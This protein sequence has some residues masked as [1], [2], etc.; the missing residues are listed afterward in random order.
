[1]VEGCLVLDLFCGDGFFSHYFYATIAGHID[2]IDKSPQ[3]I[4]HAQKWHSHPKI[5]Y[6]VQDVVL[7]DF[8]RPHYD[9][10]VWFEAIEHLSQVDYEKAV[11]RIKSAL[12]D[13]GVLIGSTP[14]VPP[15]KLG[16]AN[17]EHQNEFSEVQQLHTFLARDFEQI[18]I[19][20]TIY[21]I[22]GGGQ[23]QTA[24]FTLKQPK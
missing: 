6:L 18:Q 7:Q 2:A 14:L 5:N 8:P 12:G 24:Y 16:Q 3:A 20:V 23:R 15:D 1:M 9:V 13:T 4:A 19:D 21:P 17:W 22:V 10:I 11:G